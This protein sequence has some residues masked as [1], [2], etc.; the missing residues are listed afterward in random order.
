MGLGDQLPLPDGDGV[1]VMLPELGRGSAPSH[2][3]P[4]LWIN[5]VMLIFR[6]CISLLCL[7]L[8]VSPVA[9]PT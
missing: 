5:N 6:T 4:A 1:A 3:G 2:R 9:A 8:H 7:N